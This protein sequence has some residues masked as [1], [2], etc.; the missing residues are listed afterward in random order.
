MQNAAIMIV[1]IALASGPA[2]GGKSSGAGKAKHESAAGVI[3]QDLEF[4]M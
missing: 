1:L 2:F 4:G 3:W